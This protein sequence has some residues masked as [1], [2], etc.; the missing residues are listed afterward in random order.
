MLI[1]SAELLPVS[2][3]Q[4]ILSIL[5]SPSNKLKSIQHK[6]KNPIDHFFI[7]LTL[8]EYLFKIFLVLLK[9]K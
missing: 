7:V 9:L 4:L 6:E 8:S 3:G 1:F 5:K 2:D